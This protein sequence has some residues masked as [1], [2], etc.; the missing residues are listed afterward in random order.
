M[1]AWKAARLHQPSS[2]I[3]LEGY[4]IWSSVA[5]SKRLLSISNARMVLD[6][7]LFR[8]D[9]GG[10]PE[11]IRE[12]QSKRFKDVKKVDNVVEYDSRWRKCRKISIFYVFESVD[13][14]YT[15]CQFWYLDN[16]MI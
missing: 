12:N 9:K 6:V 16:Q 13:W 2:S 14:R 4:F 11:K 5:S 3:W 15:Q 8:A 1:F 7:E 10:C